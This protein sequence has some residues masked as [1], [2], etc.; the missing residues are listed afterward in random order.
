MLEKALFDVLDQEQY[1]F[2][3]REKLKFGIQIILAE[4]NKLLIIYLVSLLLDCIIPTLIVHLSFFL[5]RQVCFGYHFKSLLTCIGWSMVAFPLAIY[6]LV[7]FHVNF[8]VNL[9][10][11]IFSILLL[12]I[13]ILAP[14]GT[15]N[16]PVISK[17]HRKYLRRKIKIRLLLLVGVYFFSSLFTSVA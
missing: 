15:N 12:M 8:S 4:F 14:K 1:S 3:E 7:D 16:Q 17:E 2:L 5:L 9:L 10:N 13:Y 11:I 6:Y